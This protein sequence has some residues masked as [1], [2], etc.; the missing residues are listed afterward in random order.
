[1]G[2]E[3]PSLLL[4]DLSIC[5]MA[6]FVPEWAYVFSHVT[7]RDAESI[8]ICVLVIDLP[9]MEDCGKV[10]SESYFVVCESL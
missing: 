8:T 1:M 9:W 7:E 4:H 6:V 3:T 5:E 2:S 10:N